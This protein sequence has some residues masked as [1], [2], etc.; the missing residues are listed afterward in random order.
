M[1][2]LQ[3]HLTTQTIEYKTRTNVLL[4]VRFLSLAFKKDLTKR[5]RRSRARSAHQHLLRPASRIR[6]GLD[7]SLRSRSRLRR[8]LTFERIFL[9]RDLIL[10]GY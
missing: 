5:I 7:S 2:D 6:K 1:Y 10:G 8:S 4:F 9:E 3:K